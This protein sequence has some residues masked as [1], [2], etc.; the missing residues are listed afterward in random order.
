MKK[1]SKKGF[2]LIELI[3]VLA[4][5]AVLAAIIIPTTFGAITNAKEAADNANLDSLNAAVRMQKILDQAKMPV[6][7]STVQVALTNASITIPS[8]MADTGKSFNWDDTAKKFVIST[9]AGDALT[10][11]VGP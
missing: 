5:L 7:Y 6:T 3:V 10:S 2:T 9:G 8:V 1:L 11:K 4:I